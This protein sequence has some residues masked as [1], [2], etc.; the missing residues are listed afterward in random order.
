MTVMPMRSASRWRRAGD[1]ARRG[2]GEDSAVA[3][4]GGR[5]RQGI[6]GRRQGGRPAAE[7]AHR[8]VGGRGPPVQSGQQPH[9]AD[10]R[11]DRDRRDRRDHRGRRRAEQAADGHPGRGL[12]RLDPVRGHRVGRWCGD[13]HQAG[14]HPEGDGR[15]LRGRAVSGVRGTRTA[16]RPADQPGARQRDADRQLPHGQFPQ[17]SSASGD[18]SRRAAG[19]LLCVAQNSGSQPGVYMAFHSALFAPENQPEE[20]GT[21]DPSNQQLADLAKSVGASE[22]RNMHRPAGRT[23]GG[24][25]RRQRRSS[26]P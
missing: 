9:S 25:A 7:P 18:Y 20:N 8:V 6:G 12:R 22:R 17:R 14:Q 21:S 26:P 23:A 15:H 5:A 11:R 24:R 1:Q 16:V 2:K 13:R 10:H 4:A 3:Q 19:A